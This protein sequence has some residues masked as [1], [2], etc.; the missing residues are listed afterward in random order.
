MTTITGTAGNDTIYGSGTEDSI[1]G[2]GGDDV[3]SGQGHDTLDGGAGND[4]VSSGP[5]ATLYGGSG[6]DSIEAQPNDDITTGAG[7]DT[8]F[9]HFDSFTIEDFT[10]GPGG[11]L[12]VIGTAGHPGISE[13]DFPGFATGYASLTQQ[14]ADTVL[15]IVPFPTHLDA[16]PFQPNSATILFKNLTATTLSADNIGNWGPFGFISGL[17]Y[18]SSVGP[19]TGTPFSDQLI[20]G[21]GPSQLSGGDGND[22]L[23][24]GNGP[25]T[26]FGGAGDDLLA[27]GKGND[28]LDGGEGNDTLWGGGGNDTINGGAG[29]DLIHGQG[30]DN[31]ETGGPGADTFFVDP[32]DGNTWI[33]DF[34]TAEGDR[35]VVPAG[36]SVQIYHPTGID[37]V[38]ATLS[39]GQII[40]LQGA[41][42]GTLGN[43]IFDS[44]AVGSPAETIFG[45][46]SGNETLAGERGNDVIVDGAGSAVMMGGEGNDTLW[47]GAGTDYLY[48]GD[49]NDKLVGQGG[50]NLLVGGRGSDAFVITPADTSDW[51]V[52]FNKA[53]GDRVV[54]PPGVT[55]ATI[56]QYDFGTAVGLST[57]Q[58]IGLQG[59]T[60]SSLG[61]DWFFYY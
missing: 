34:N 9:S 13:I 61:N 19:H 42:L 3:L 31:L 25:D 40:N 30:G 35:V 52:D 49:G 8:V 55:I 5:S 16:P 57:G 2:L 22:T 39:T 59:V 12:L 28:R 17:R 15:T 18:E 11:D 10:P 45:G 37:V 21:P 14:G 36:L 60:A 48:G 27:D 58:A 44:S 29:N 7:Q 26:Q 56:Q 46:D 1:Q 4:Q 54:L 50:T 6:N 32:G 43:W 33:S 38:V 24:G 23:F 20:A 53:E 47:G 41:N 51:I